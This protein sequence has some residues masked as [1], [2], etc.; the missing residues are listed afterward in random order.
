MI[1]KV[2]KFFSEVTVELRKVSWPT[3]SELRDATW[4]VIISSFMLGIYIGVTDVV[5]SKMLR[6]FIR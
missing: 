5:L 2:K 4:I 6:F 3:R 1:G